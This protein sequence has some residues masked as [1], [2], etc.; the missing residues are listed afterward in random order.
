MGILTDQKKTRRISTTIT[1][2]ER[3]P[4]S[5]EIANRGVPNMVFDYSRQQKL[6]PNTLG[7][8]AVFNE[9]MAVPTGDKS[10]LRT[11]NASGRP[12]ALDVSVGGSPDVRSRGI[13]PG[14]ERLSPIKGE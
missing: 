13:N 8:R 10:R 4:T 2:R 11:M 9:S 14:K 1:Q 5:P 6:V 12:K 3:P 7:S